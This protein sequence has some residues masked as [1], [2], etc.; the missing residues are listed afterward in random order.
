MALDALIFDLD[1]TLVDTNATH[2]EGWVRAFARFGYKVPADR[3]APEIG[4]GGDQLVP[5]VLG[6]ETAEREGKALRDASAEEYV[7]L[8]KS[9]RFRV[10]DGALAL[11]DEARRRGLKTALATSSGDDHLDATFGSAGVDLRERVDVVVGKSDVENSKPAPDTVT[12]AVRKLGLSPAQCAMFGDT[13]YDALGAR[14]AGVV[15]LGVLSSNI[16]F[17]ERAL[18]AAGARRVYRDVAH[19]LQG[20][21]EVLRVASPGSAHLTTELVEGLMREALAVAEEGMAAGEAPIGCVIAGG[22]GRVLVRAYNEMNRTGN[23]TAHAEI[24]AFA[25]G[26]G[27]IPI[28][29]RDLVLVST[30]EPCVM[31]TGAAMEGAV[32]T[33]VFGLRAPADSGSG[34]VRPPESPESQMPRIVGD[35]LARESRALLARWYETHQGEPQAA[36]VGQL[37]ELTDGLEVAA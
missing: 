36:Y 30:L 10:F 12:A 24:M 2:V 29:A 33:I 26:A 37:L 8:A 31:C 14:R 35:T 5:S 16:G 6:E 7:R 18:R 11:L 20:L 34:R 17:E 4:K 3:I 1:G 15:T 19:V 28:E 13:P 22:D 21:D 9:R 27:V 23:K 25:K 32:D